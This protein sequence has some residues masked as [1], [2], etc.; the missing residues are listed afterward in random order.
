MEDVHKQIFKTARMFE[1][2][3]DKANEARLSLLRNLVGRFIIVR[4]N[5]LMVN[6]QGPYPVGEDAIEQYLNQEL[7]NF[8]LD[9]E[10]AIKVYRHYAP[11]VNDNPAECKECGLMPPFCCHCKDSI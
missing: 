10:G 3:R 1:F 5:Q 4:E 8:D 9:L 11:P 2:K 7:L 6:Y